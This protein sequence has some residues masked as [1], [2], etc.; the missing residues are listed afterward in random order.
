M[1]ENNKQHTWKQCI[2]STWKY[3]F[4]PTYIK[5][6][7]KQICNKSRIVTYLFM[8]LFI[9]QEPIW[10]ILSAWIADLLITNFCAAARMA[11]RF[12]MMSWASHS[13]DSSICSFTPQH[14]YVLAI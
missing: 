11:V 2:G 6:K 9:A 12:K 13:V 8:L 3:C 4:C 5:Q 7:S 1:R 14:S 10:F